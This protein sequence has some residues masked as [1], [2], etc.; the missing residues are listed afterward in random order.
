MVATGPSGQ[1]TVLARNCLG[2]S[3]L[4]SPCAGP[5]A[6]L[7]A[8]VAELTRQGKMEGLLVSVAV[9][10]PFLPTDFVSRLIA[11]LGDGAVAYAAWGED[12]YPPNAIWRLESL[13]GLPSAL[14]QANAPASLKTLQ[15]SL[16]A[17]RIDWGECA[18][19]PFANINTLDD[20]LALQRAARM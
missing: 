1:G 15:R 8:A 20:L 11:G 14:N 2:V 5:L 12:F 4:E 13:Q 16:G 3:D 7:A 9:D 17:H 10:T 6:G 19:N 18:V